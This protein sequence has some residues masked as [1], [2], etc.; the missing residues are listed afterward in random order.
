MILKLFQNHPAI[1]Y[2]MY[3]FSMIKPITNEFY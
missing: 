3:Q 1:K 2:W